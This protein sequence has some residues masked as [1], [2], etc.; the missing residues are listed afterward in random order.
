MVSM[1]VVLDQRYHQ[2]VARF[3]QNTNHILTC[4]EFCAPS[5]V[6]T[7]WMNVQQRLHAIKSSL[8]PNPYASTLPDILLPEPLQ[9]V[10]TIP[11]PLL[12]FHILPSKIRG[13]DTS[14]LIKQPTNEPHMNEQLSISDPL[15]VCL[16]TGASIP[17][18]YRN[19]S[20]TYIGFENGGVLLDCG[21]GTYG[22]MFRKF[23]TQL[24]DHLQN[25][26]VVFISHLHADHHLGLFSILSKRQ[27]LLEANDNYTPINIIGP[28]A[29]EFWLEEYSEIETL[30]YKF[31]DCNNITEY[32]AL[33]YN[34]EISI[35]SVEVSHCPDAFGAVVEYLSDSNPWKIV[36]S[37]DTRPCNT[38][39][40]A[41]KNA[42]LLIHEATFE[43]GMEDD[44]IAKYHSTT[45]EAIDV[46]NRMEAKYLIMNH[47]SQRYPKIPLFDW[48]LPNVGIAFDLMTVHLSKLNDI[49]QIIPQIQDIFKE[50]Q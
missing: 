11:E 39:V 44:A 2:W 49:S 6:F 24:D 4:K 48:N 42:D 43:N 50:E 36:Y 17:S 34:E 28:T 16:G 9:D 21:E 18:K 45:H 10:F 46:A 13:I 15:V 30:R 40:N 22:Q 32:Q 31:T 27:S 29:F 12:I 7:S 3:N 47:F 8:F 25:L 33:Y 19:V 1:E 5:T 35:K 26:N 41:G 20:A 37:G 23:G 38:L 14:S